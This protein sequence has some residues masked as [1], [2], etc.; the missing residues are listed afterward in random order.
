MNLVRIEKTPKKDPFIKRIAEDYLHQWLKSSYRKPLILRGARQV[1]KSTL[2]H[3][4]CQNHN[5]KLLEINLEKVKLFSLNSDHFKIDELLDEIQ[6]KTSLRIDKNTLIFFDEIQESPLLLKSLRYFFEE[7]NDLV[8]VAAGSL[9]ELALRDDN[10]SFPVGRVEFYN[11]GPMTFS[12]FLWATGHDFVFEQL[13]DLKFSPALHEKARQLL[14][15]YFYTGGMPA[16]VKYY[17]E[18]KSIIGVRK[19]QEQIIQTYLADFPKYNSRINSERIERI[20]YSAVNHLGKKVIWKK[21]DPLSQARETRRIIELL[22]DA[23]VLISCGH[24]HGNSV[25]LKGEE[26]LNTK[27]LFFLDVGLVNCLMGISYEVLSQIE[28]LTY[29]SKGVVTEQFVAQHLAYLR[30]EKLPYL[31]YWL[32]DKA[33]HKAEID[34]LMEHEGEVIPLEVKAVKSGHLKSLFYF[35]HEKKKN[36]AVKLSLEPF[37]KEMARHKIGEEVVEFSLINLPLY[38]I[39]YLV[40]QV[41]SQKDHGTVDVK[42]NLI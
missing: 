29:N 22:V 28:K 17:Q 30:P 9:L 25:P 16:V 24:C 33:N 39:E 14:Q 3:I 32:K 35:A 21:I 36:K 15:I 20:F 27:K 42:Q 19:I 7:R 18:E 34:F 13:R 38:A 6:I 31:F 26:D 12:E 4:F 1:G 37:S 2:V 8:V 23:R 10:F 40:T 41:L 5:L 11:L